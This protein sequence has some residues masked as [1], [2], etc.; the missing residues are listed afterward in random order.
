MQEITVRVGMCFDC[1]V[2][3]ICVCRLLWTQW[4]GLDRT[5]SVNIVSR[6]VLLN[7]EGIILSVLSAA[8]GI[9]LEATKQ[10]FKLPSSGR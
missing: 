1:L 10:K 5:G 2:F 3:A 8:P 7:L 6:L 4:L 9:V